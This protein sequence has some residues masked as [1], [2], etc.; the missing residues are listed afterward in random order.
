M[1]E[2]WNGDENLCNLYQQIAG[3]L[4]YAAQLWPELMFSVSQ[5][6][7]VMSWPTQENLVLAR[8]VVKCIIGSL[9]LKITDRPDDP[10]DPLSETNND[11]MMFTD[12]DWTTSIDVLLYRTKLQDRVDTPK[13][14]QR[15]RQQEHGK[16]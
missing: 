16:I 3:S 12:S 1:D 9:D 7:R 5:L 14:T 11:L 2:D 15:N 6:P 4:N 10:N 13:P 8:Q